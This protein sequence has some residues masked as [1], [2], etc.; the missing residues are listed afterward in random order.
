MLYDLFLFVCDNLLLVFYIQL[1]KI[2]IYNS[3]VNR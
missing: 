1:K 2:T 3:Y